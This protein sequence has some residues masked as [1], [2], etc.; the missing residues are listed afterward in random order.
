MLVPVRCACGT[1]NQ[2][3][4]SEAGKAFACERCGATIRLAKPEETDVPPLVSWKQVLVG[5]A[6]LVIV[7]LV[8]LVAAPLT[9]ITTAMQVGSFVAMGMLF[10]GMATLMLGVFWAW[11]TA[12]RYD[13]KRAVSSLLGLAFSN[14]SLIEVPASIRHHF[15]RPIAAVKYGALVALLGMLVLI[16]AVVVYAVGL[17]MGMPL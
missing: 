11:L 13:P 9:S 8:M 17:S 16:E 2:I 14:Q 12:L 10:P 7:L 3:D 15:S 5:L 6:V 4:D 1:I